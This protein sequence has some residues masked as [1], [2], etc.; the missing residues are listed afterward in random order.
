MVMRWSTPSVDHLDAAPRSLR[1]PVGGEGGIVAADGDEVVDA[2]ALQGLHDRLEV[3]GLLGG[4]GPGRLEDG[5]SLQVNGRDV[6]GAEFAYVA[7]V[8][9][10]QPAEA[11]ENA[12]HPGAGPLCGKGRCADHTVDT[13]RRPSTDENSESRH[14]CLH[15]R[16]RSEKQLPSTLPDQPVRSRAGTS[17]HPPIRVKPGAS[18][19]NHTRARARRITRGREPAEAHGLPFRHNP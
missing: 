9:L 10:H 7:G 18:P 14:P 17:P 4:V 5:A 13:G 19:Q 1:H 15:S 11:L 12:D 2:E 16:V 6:F 8:A 3:A